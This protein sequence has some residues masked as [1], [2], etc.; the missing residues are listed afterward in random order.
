MNARE[1]D[2]TLPNN[3]LLITLHKTI[4]NRHGEKS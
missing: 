4:D 1:Q 3:Q 2:C